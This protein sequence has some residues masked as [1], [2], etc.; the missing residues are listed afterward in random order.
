MAPKTRCYCYSL[1]GYKGVCTSYIMGGWWRLSAVFSFLFR[2]VLC[3]DLNLSHLLNPYH[4][5]HLTSI[6]LLLLSALNLGFHSLHYVGCVVIPVMLGDKRWICEFCLKRLQASHLQ[7]DLLQAETL[8]WRQSSGRRRG[9]RE[10]KT[11]E[12]FQQCATSPIAKSVHRRRN[13][14]LFND[15][16]L[17]SWNRKTKKP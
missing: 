9:R 15:Q 14:F 16:T 1:V 11:S 13:S 4:D 17:L 7:P 3:C 8:V 5:L 6:S 10:G 2:P 12:T